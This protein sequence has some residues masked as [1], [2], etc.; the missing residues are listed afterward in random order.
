MTIVPRHR[1]LR[2]AAGAWLAVSLVTLIVLLLR[3]ELQANERSA[4]S[5]LVPLYFLG[6]PLG[7]LG[8][9]AGNKL[10]LALYVDC[11]WV[12]GIAWEGLLLWLALAVLG[13]AQW[14]VLLPWLARKMRQLADYLFVR[15]AEK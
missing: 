13:Y 4:L 7:H 12:P 9:L 10:K 3:P 2:L 6:F 1:V 5:V 11:H 14:F 8:L 15:R